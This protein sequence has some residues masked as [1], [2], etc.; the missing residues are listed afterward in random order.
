MK[1]NNVINITEDVLIVGG[2]AVGVAQ[3]ETILG[4]VLLSVQLL[5]ILYKG[6][7]LIIKHLKNKDYNSA[8]DQAKDTINKIEETIDNSN[9]IK[10]NGEKQDS[11]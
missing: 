9:V 5:I 2:V 11:K 4:I 1:L 6:I 7:S 3:I 10:N 8:V